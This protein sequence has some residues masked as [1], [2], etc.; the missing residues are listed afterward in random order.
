[1]DKLTDMLKRSG[2]ITE[3]QLDLAIQKQRVLGGSPALYL[4]ADG[5]IAEDVLQSYLAQIHPVPSDCR[6][7][8]D[9]EP[10]ALGLLDRDR[11]ARLEVIPLKLRGDRLVVLAVDPSNEGMHREVRKK[12]GIEQIVACPV[13]ELRFLWHLE[14]WYGIDAPQHLRS[15]MEAHFTDNSR[16]ESQRQGLETEDDSLLYDPMAGMGAGLGDQGLLAQ[17]P[18]GSSGESGEEVVPILDEELPLLIVE[19]PEEA[20]AADRMEAEVNNSGTLGDGLS[21]LPLDQM[22]Q[23]L[24]EAVS[25]DDLYRIFLRFGATYLDSILVFK[26]QG[27]QATGWRAAGA[28]IDSSRAKNIVQPVAGSRILAPATGSG[29]AI[30][31]ETGTDAD[32]NL[33]SKIRDKEGQAVVS[34]VVSVRNR[35]VLLVCGAVKN[36]A[37]PDQVAG[38]LHTLCSL[39]ASAV[40]RIIARKKKSRK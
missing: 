20:A 16:H 29:P 14:Q 26:V 28:M 30:V 11:A 1:M 27:G 12:S 40:L 2:V 19:T 36:N 25:L 9:P 10:E 8:E 22:E 4:L 5:L 33:A 35:P 13:N 39:S 6:Y 32:E 38:Q 15:A 17:I 7:D 21:P 24:N 37:A 18:L 31:T 3:A 34:D 23:T